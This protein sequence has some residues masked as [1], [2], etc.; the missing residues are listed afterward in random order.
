M[1]FLKTC[2]ICSSVK[3]TFYFLTVQFKVRWQIMDEPGYKDLKDINGII[4]F[5]TSYPARQ[6]HS[7][8]IPGLIA[9]RDQN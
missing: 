1:F 7:G 5:H 3:V 8:V 6:L 4:F 2:R 9:T